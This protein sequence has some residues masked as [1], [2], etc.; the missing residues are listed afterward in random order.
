MI[1]FDQ[2]VIIAQKE[3]LAMSSPFVAICLA[4]LNY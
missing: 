1:C 2:V 4:R 3:K